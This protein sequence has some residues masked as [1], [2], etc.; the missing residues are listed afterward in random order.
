MYIY[1]FLYI[2]LGL[3]NNL[4]L[5]SFFL[6]YF[7]TVHME[8]QVQWVAG[9]IW[10]GNYVFI[11]VVV[12]YSELTGLIQ[13]LNGGQITGLVCHFFLYL[14]WLP[15][16][17]NTQKALPPSPTTLVKPARVWLNFSF[18]TVGSLLHVS[19]SSPLL[20][21][22][23]S[24]PHPFTSLFLFLFINLFPNFIPSSPFSRRFPLPLPS[25]FWLLPT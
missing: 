14:T 2:R 7:Y 8:L 17:Y 20:N 6:A 13:S 5:T 1:V 18:L 21:S 11:Y 23:L 24:F 19:L 25:P 16:F 22:S 10:C 9:I 4:H 15:H 12:L 3:Y